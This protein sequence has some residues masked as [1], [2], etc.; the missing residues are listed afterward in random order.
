M[1]IFNDL[2]EIRRTENS[3]IT[4][5][6]FDGV[7]TGHRQIIQTV[8]E[9]AGNSSAK[10]FLITFDPH[11]RKIISSDYRLQLLNTLSEKIE[12]LASLGIENLLIV[13]F[14]KEFSQTSAD[15]FIIKYLVNGIGVKEVVIGHDHHF[16]KSR[17]G[18]LDNLIGIGKKSNFKVTVIPGYTVNGEV[19]SST[20]IRKALLNG[21]VMTAN[22]MLGR[23]YSFSGIV[24]VGD[25]R[26]R[27]LGFPTANLK[28][29]DED[30][31]LPQIGIY[32]VKCFIDEQK[33][34]GLLSI[35][36]R[37]TFHETGE[38]IPEVYLFD[39]DEDIYGKTVK[40]NLV[41]R[42]RDEQKF[43]SAEELIQQMNRDKEVGLEILSKLIN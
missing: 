21:E 37:P 16:G 27:E 38:V 36:R 35:G 2:T 1:Q 33:F 15:E 14:T 13:N 34:Y 41:E 10:S 42:I 25:R 28:I 26:G 20:K 24:V 30:K 22:K 5:G 43:S 18:S 7:H 23:N 3:I 11:P 40:V 17:E 29:D 19:V 39:F 12:V 9:K 4:L 32:A 8:V 31:L 6:T